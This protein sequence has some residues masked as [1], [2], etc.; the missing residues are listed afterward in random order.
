[1]FVFLDLDEVSTS[2]TGIVQAM[3]GALH[4]YAALGS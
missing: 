2:Y 3:L 4:P 1:M